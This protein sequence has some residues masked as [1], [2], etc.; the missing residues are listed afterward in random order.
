MVYAIAIVSCFTLTL[1]LGGAFME[2]VVPH[3]GPLERWIES[4]D[5]CMYDEE[6]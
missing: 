1:C 5:I 3:I 4:L 2:Y 6:E